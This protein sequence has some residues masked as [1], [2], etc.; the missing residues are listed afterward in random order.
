M[1]NVFQTIEKFM[2]GSIDAY[3]H[4]MSNE[5]MDL[6][7]NILHLIND[8]VSKVIIRVEAHDQ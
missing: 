4:L 2:K 7:Q 1:L 6:N 3:P 8:M 5:N